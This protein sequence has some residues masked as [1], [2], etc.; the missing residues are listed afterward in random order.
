[1]VSRRVFMKNGAFALV[2]LGFAPSFLARTAYAQ[3]SDQARQTAHRDL[4]ARRRRRPQRRR[5]VWRRR[6]LP[7]AADHRDR[8]TGIRR[9]RGASISTDS[10]ASTRD[11]SRSR[12]FWDNRALAIVHACGS[13]DATRSHFDAQDYMETATPGV[14]S[15][16]DGW[17]NRYLQAARTAARRG[18]SPG[19]GVGDAV[20]RRVADAAAAADAAGHGACARDEPDR[21]VRHSRRSGH[22]HDG[23]VVRSAVR[24]GR[25]PR[26]ERHGS[27]SVR[28]DQDAQ[29]RRPRELSAGQRRRLPAQP[30]RPGAQADRTADEGRRRPRG[31]VRGR[32]RLGHARQP[33]VVTGS[34]RQPAR[35]FLAQP[36][37][38]R[39]R[40]RQPHGGHGHPDDVGV[41]AGGRRERQSRN[42]SRTRQRDDGHRRRRARRQGVRHVAG[43][44]ASRS[45]TMA[46]TSPSRPISATSSAR[47]VVRHLGVSD[48]R[49]IFPGYA[50]SPAKFPGLFA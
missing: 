33:G 2:S 42:R 19:Y 9:W 23:R 41:R 44:R 3:G 17:L 20:P 31:G 14:K 39:H 15:T 4:P 1:M 50:I 43:P 7:R 25:R 40:S 21:P 5:A 47:V 22:R 6:V 45:V 24:G 46:A 32:R 16:P 26:A 29:G 8:A 35:R 13:P 48:P 10:S 49:S 36:R 28:R 34:A 30:V 37:G 38:A 11:C 18:Q 27:R 12:P